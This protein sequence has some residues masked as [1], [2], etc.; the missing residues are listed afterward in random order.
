MF[1][2]TDI[3][4]AIAMLLFKYRPWNQFTADVL[5]E[6]RIY[7]PTR[8]QLNDPAELVHP[9]RFE[10]STW[11]D[12]F[13]HARKG[14]SNETIDLSISIRQTLDRLRVIMQI[15]G[16]KVASSEWA[17]YLGVADEFWGV[18]EAVFDKAEVH[19][20]IR[21]YALCLAEDRIHLYDNEESI[22]RRLNTKLDTLG[23]LSLS[24]RCDCPVMWAHYSQ[25]HQ[26]V[27]I[28][29]DS[30]RCRLIGAAKPIEYIENRPATTV[31]SVIENLYRKA[32]AWQYE[33]E[34]SSWACE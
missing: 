30:D 28:V 20:A 29:L 26:G 2:L 31:D 23:V 16:N 17:P 1:C 15:P 18:V 14:I 22:V 3:Y 19:D 11:A 27:I 32:K 6:G 5:A 9:V 12:A 21:Y 24:G 34:E 13:F 4:R 33:K 8:V 25:N 10:V 7:F